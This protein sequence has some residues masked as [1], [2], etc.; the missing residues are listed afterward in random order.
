[1]SLRR[2]ARSKL[3]LL[4]VACAV[5]ATGCITRSVRSV[6]VDD[7][8]MRVLLRQQKRGTRIVDHGFQQPAF[9]AP[10]RIV[11]ILSRIDLRNEDDGQRVPA[12]PLETLF[13]IADGI[14][15][16][17]GEADSTQEV[18]VQSIRRD[19]RWGVFERKYLTSLLCYLKDDLL[20]IHVSRSDWEIPPRKEELAARGGQDLPETWVGEFP[21]D[22][23]LVADR[24]MTL[25]DQQSLAVDWRD[26]IFAKPTRTRVTPG[27]RVVRR[28][29]LMETL[30]DETDYGPE[31]AHSVD[32]LSLEQ[33]RELTELEE[34]RQRG[35]LTETEYNA[36]K[37]RILTGEAPA[38]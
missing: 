34:A 38:P 24:G 36:A 10:V 2:L 1:M 22:F 28:E 23:R 33:L 14:G 20:Y 30:E 27:G 29:V 8:Y 31:P 37:R 35:E 3:L 17:L 18:V 4:L 19:K 15:K 26:E 6:V 7:G 16:A 25:V 13:A 11:H 32:E 9:I 12:I 5:S 21:L